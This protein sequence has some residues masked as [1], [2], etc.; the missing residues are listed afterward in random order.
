MSNKEKRNLYNEKKIQLETLI[1]EIAGMRRLIVGQDN[2]FFLI[3]CKLEGL[4][5]LVEQTQMTLY[6]R[7]I[8]E[9]LGL[10]NSLDKNVYGQ[11]E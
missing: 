6:R 9:C 11:F 1:E 4:F 5:N 7:V 3:L 2:L 10:L 8:F